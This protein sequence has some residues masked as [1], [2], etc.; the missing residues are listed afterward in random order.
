MG[1][2]ISGYTGLYCVFGDP[3]QH[4]FSPRLHNK[5]FDK[6]NIDGVYVAFTA[7]EKTIEAAMNAVRVLGIRGCSVTMPNKLACIPYL[8]EIDPTAEM[9]GSVNTFVV[10][11]GK[12]KGY[13]TDGYGFL[14]T[15]EEM[16]VQ[17]AGNK[18]VLLGLGGAG[19]SVALTAAMEYDLGEISVFNRANGKSWSHA[20]EVVKM[21]NEKTSCKAKLCDLNDKDLLKAEMA[22][23]QMLGNTTN[24]G[25]G[26]LEGQSVV[27]DVS[28]FHKGLAVQDAIYSPAKSRLLELADEAGCQYT[29]G[30]SMLFYQGAKQFKLWTGVDMPLTVDDLEIDKNLRTKKTSR[31][32]S[33]YC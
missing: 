17:I 4:S 27:P 9:I 24:V 28:F 29:N 21:I 1:I 3:V 2:P 20:Q 31:F 10:N 15:F 8:D 16:G 14:H 22:D 33:A 25:M 12:I 26:E 23:A 32:K 11:D 6:A 13:N 5:A 7:N 19:S 30:L 18:L